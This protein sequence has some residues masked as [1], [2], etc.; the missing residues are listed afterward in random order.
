MNVVVLTLHD[1]RDYP[2]T[3]W[4][5]CAKH[6][7]FVLADEETQ[8]VASTE[9]RDF[10]VE[11]FSNYINNG[12]VEKRVL[13]IHQA[14]GVDAIVSFGE[15][16]VIRAARLRAKLGLPGQSLE[17]A[18]AFRC[19]VKMK[20]LLRD[21]K[22]ELPAFRRL[23]SPLDLLEF[24]DEHGL[25][26]YVK[27]TTSSGST[28]GKK[29]STAVELEKALSSDFKA[30]IPFSEY[31]SDFMVESFI[32]GELHHVD[33]FWNGKSLSLVVA[34]RYLS[35]SLDLESMAKSVALTSVTLPPESPLARRLVEATDEVLRS[36]P[37]DC[38][39][40]FHAEFF[41]KGEDITFCEIA[42]RT[43]GTRVASTFEQA[44]GFNLNQLAFLS[45]AGLPYDIAPATKIQM[46]G[47]TVVCPADTRVLKDPT[48]CP[49]EW[50]AEYR[51]D[52][53][54]GDHSDHRHYSGDKIASAVVTGESTEEVQERAEQ[55]NRWFL[56][57]FTDFYEEAHG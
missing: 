49:F 12:L 56:E 44:T 38:P 31:V 14:H 55:F 37:S 29:I 6:R 35:P 4:L 51:S 15:D 9:F 13:E 24:S 48:P 57:S 1:L 19:K 34:S 28:W 11:Y 50:V 26:L 46:A 20:S 53:K 43:G 3:Q 32:D 54:K 10:S 33:G 16:D 42:S 18:E 2:F 30:R 39:F 41:V 7:L 36:L 40:P 23:S 52:A 17:S 21:S 8:R 25:P 27:P 47:W 45:Q 22:V 5:D